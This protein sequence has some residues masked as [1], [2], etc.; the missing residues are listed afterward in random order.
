MSSSREKR[1]IFARGKSLSFDA[2]AKAQNGRWEVLPMVVDLWGNCGGVSF[3][4]H[5]DVPPLCFGAD[6]VRA[7]VLWLRVQ[8][9]AR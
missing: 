1:P 8:G 4:L 3:R 2:G 5:P 9:L 7:L 6:E